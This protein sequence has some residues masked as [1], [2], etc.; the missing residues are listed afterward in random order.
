MLERR[1]Q[2]EGHFWAL[3]VCCA[4]STTGALPAAAQNFPFCIKGCDFRRTSRRLQF[5]ELPQYQATVSGRDA[6]CDAN[7]YF[8]ASAELRPNRSRQTRRRF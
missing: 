4:A 7:P 2:C 3:G 8:N 5:F 6:D 1:T